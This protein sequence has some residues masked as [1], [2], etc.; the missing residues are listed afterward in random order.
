MKDNIFETDGI[1]APFVLGL[2][3][4]RIFVSTGIGQRELDYVLRTYK[5]AGL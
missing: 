1:S 2:L 4:P 3:R 5:P